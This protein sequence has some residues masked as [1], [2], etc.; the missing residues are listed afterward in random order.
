M[1]EIKNW[2]YLQEYDL[3]RM[4]SIRIRKKPQRLIFFS[5]RPLCSS[6]V[7]GTEP[8]NALDSRKSWPA[9]YKLNHLCDPLGPEQQSGRTGQLPRRDRIEVQ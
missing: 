3:R 5:S 9:R 8:A 7:P 4:L 2:L 6:G 1:Q